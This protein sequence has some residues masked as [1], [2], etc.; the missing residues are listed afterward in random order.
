MR[1]IGDPTTLALELSP[2][3]EGD[4]GLRAVRVFVCGTLV[5]DQ[6]TQAYVPQLL[7]SLHADTLRARATPE[8]PDTRLTGTPESVFRTLLSGSPALT[9]LDHCRASATARFLDWGSPTDHLLAYLVPGPRLLCAHREG[10]RILAT[11]LPKHRLITTLTDAA[12]DLETN[13]TV[14][15]D[16]TRT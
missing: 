16:R 6:S 9:G 2:P 10:G 15:R 1:L 8:T 4:T 11:A 14:F 3:D 5:T 13:Y 12:R 7:R